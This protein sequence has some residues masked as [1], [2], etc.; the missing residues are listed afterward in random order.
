MN[1]WLKLDERSLNEPT[2]KSKSGVRL[3][4][5]LSPFDIPEAVRGFREAETGWFCIQF[6]YPD[7]EE[8]VSRKVSETMIVE[9]GK[10]SG[11]IQAIRVNVKGLDVG[12]VRLDLSIKVNRELNE[13]LS[14]FF[15]TRTSTFASRQH[16]LTKRIL[17]EKGRDLIDSLSLASA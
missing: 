4:V 3:E 9:E 7:S 1:S 10:G 14:K 11:R 2:V 5:S 17:N 13:G 12:Q 15:K 6:R 16:G 8:C